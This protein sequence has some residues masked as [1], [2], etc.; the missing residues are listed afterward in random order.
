MNQSGFSSLLIQFARAPALGQVKTRMQ[1]QLSVQESLELHCR[2][3]RHTYQTLTATGVALSADLELW[4]TGTDNSAFFADLR[5]LPTLRM[6]RGGDLGARMFDALADGLQR[7][8]AVIL[9]G[10]DCPAL[11]C[12]HFQFVVDR[13]S[14]AEDCVLGPAIDG[15]YVLIGLSKVDAYLFKE[16]AWGTDKV[17][18]QTRQ[19]LAALGWRWTELE[20]LSDVDTFA[21]LSS[22]TY[23]K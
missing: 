21:D 8:S 16:I 22:V 4:T 20:A 17:L 3:V 23:L 15:G 18:S 1:P 9:V 12:E 10:S 11:K 2:L 13:L 14:G 19:R 7:H 5:P 6:Q